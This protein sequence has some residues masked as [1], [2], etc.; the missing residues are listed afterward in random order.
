MAVTFTEDEIV[1]G[2]K[3]IPLYEKKTLLK[4]TI[5]DKQASLD[6]IELQKQDV[7]SSYDVT[8]NTLNDEIKVLES[9]LSDA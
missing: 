7:I 4:K 5:E 3:L 9:D 8:I 6:A 1:K 2:K